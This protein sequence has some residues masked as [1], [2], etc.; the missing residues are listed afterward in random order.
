M[1]DHSCAARCGLADHFFV[2]AGPY[3]ERLVCDLVF[4]YLDAA[5][6]NWHLF[7]AVLTSAQ[8]VVSGPLV[9]SNSNPIHTVALRA[10][11]RSVLSVGAWPTVMQPPRHHLTGK[12]AFNFVSVL[13]CVP[14]NRHKPQK[15]LTVWGSKRCVWISMRQCIRLLNHSGLPP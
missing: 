10:R 1:S 3:G 9:P 6:F 2:A 11:E 5:A 12:Y 4:L 15:F 7:S 8:A 13:D 14:I